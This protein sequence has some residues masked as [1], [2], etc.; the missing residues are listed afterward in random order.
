MTPINDTEALTESVIIPTHLAIKAMRDSGYRNTAYAIAELIDN[1]V[2]AEAST[3]EVLCI[4][5][6][7]ETAKRKR[8]RIH[9]IAV[10]DNGKGMP[11]EVLRRSLQFGWGT[12]LDD[13]SGIGR[14]GMGLPNASISQGKRVDVY[15]WQTGPENAFYCY[16][17][18]GEIE[19]ENML[20]VPSPELRPVPAEWIARGKAFGTTGTMVV[21]S[22]FDDERLTWKGAKATLTHT[23]A[24]VGRIYRKLINKGTLDILLIAID[25]DQ[26]LSEKK[27][28][29][30]DP[31]YLMVPSSTPAPFDEKAMFQ[32]WGEADE[33]IR[34]PFQG[35][36]YEVAVRAS[37]ALPETWPEDANDRGSKD[38]GKHA[39]K[40]LGVSIVR[41]GRELD[42]DP[43]WTNS[44]EPTERW[45]GIEV[46]FPAELDEIFGVTNNK[47]A[48]TT[49]SH[50]VN[51]DW[52]AEAEHGESLTDLKRRMAEEGDPRAGLM[53]IVDYI[54]RL[55]GK[56]RQAVKDQGKGRRGKGKR[57]D[58]VS[59]EDRASTKFKE[60]A[61]AGHVAASDSQVFD[62][63][64]KEELVSDLVNRKNYPETEAIKIADAV[65]LR[66]RKVVFIDAASEAD[67][68]FSVDEK[69]GGITE[70]VFN[71]THPAYDGL[72]KAL[73]ADTTDATDRDLVGRIQNAAETMAMLFAA[74][75][76]QE[77]ED[78][79]N[80]E[81]LRRMRQD[82]GRMARDFLTD[83]GEV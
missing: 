41:A 48:A 64:A 35:K 16:L 39:A 69:P 52:M 33:V 81:K 20:V 47:Q 68:F 77:I 18:V 8:R 10:L 14:F 83:E 58:D 74:W 37:W 63:A 57:H 79:P 70:V 44:Y 32:R 82:W 53:D 2:Q 66:A 25:G 62:D 38:Y 3:V 23:E 28:K 4:E 67:A 55:L 1:A 56:L 42:L 65:Q 19:K 78:I 75:A 17:D 6:V 60:R 40:N 49:F 5:H 24:L 36:E 72:V 34:I 76:R 21:W 9:E 26:V 29:V 22:N 73:N 15:S 59:V 43:A 31:L 46:E 7:E 13:R 80:R 51:F 30:N 11:P 12:H 45:W 71:S 61:N 27:A 50:M 54:H